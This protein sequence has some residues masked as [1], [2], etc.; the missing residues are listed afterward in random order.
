MPID[1]PIIPDSASG[2]SM[3]L[4]A[5]YLSNRPSVTLKTPPSFPMSSPSITALRFSASIE[6]SALFIALAMFICIVSRLPEILSHSIVVL[7]L[8]RLGHEAVHMLEELLWIRLERL[9]LLYCFVYPVLEFLLHVCLHR[10]V[11]QR[12]ARQVASDS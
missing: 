7:A 12:L 4:P 9:R 6:S 5:P 8:Q 1:M 3:T 11:P 10:A 2:V